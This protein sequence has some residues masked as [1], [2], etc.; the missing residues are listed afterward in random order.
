MATAA[1]F[2]PFVDELA[3]AARNRAR[4]ALRRFGETLFLALAWAALLGFLAWAWSH[5]DGD[6]FGLVLQAIVAHPGPLAV[7]L[8]GLVFGVVRASVIA[9]RHTLAQ[10][11]WSAM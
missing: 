9:V 8:A 7:L 5:V 11:W 1:F 6:R 3:L 4:A 2:H 10:G